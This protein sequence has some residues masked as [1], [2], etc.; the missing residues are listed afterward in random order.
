MIVCYHQLDY[1][2]VVSAVFFDFVRLKYFGTVYSQIAN[3]SASEGDKLLQKRKW[4]RTIFGRKGH[5]ILGA[6][7]HDQ[8]KIPIKIGKTA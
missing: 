8:W 4:R 2:I 6:S 1:Y 3:L 7:I 5:R